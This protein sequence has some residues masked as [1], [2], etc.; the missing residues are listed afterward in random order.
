MRASLRNPIWNNAIKMMAFR[1]SLLPSFHTEKL[2]P[3]NKH[4]HYDMN[5]FIAFHWLE[6]SGAG[7]G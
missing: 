1:E 6:H 4:W 7:R 5:I 2:S 3:L